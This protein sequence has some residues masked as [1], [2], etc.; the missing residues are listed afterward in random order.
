[1]KIVYNPEIEGKGPWEQ[2][3]DKIYRQLAKTFNGSIGFGD[4]TN[5]DNISG[6]WANVVTPGTTNTDFTIA[7]NLGRLPVGYL[8]MEKSAPCDV[9]TGSVVATKNNITLRASV[10]NV[11]L[12]LFIC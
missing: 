10:A 6:A 12:R 9:Y 1:L 5:A 4:G 8:V 3:M 11:T 7:H 2:M